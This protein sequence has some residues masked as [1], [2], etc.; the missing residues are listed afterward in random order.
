LKL[1][2]EHVPSFSVLHSV[3]VR[4]E[5]VVVAGSYALLRRVGDGPWEVLHQGAKGRQIQCVLSTPEGF[6]GLAWASGKGTAIFSKDGAKWTGRKTP[7]DEPRALGRAPD[8]TLVA[9]GRWESGYSRDGGKTWTAL[10]RGSHHHPTTMY[11][12]GHALWACSSAGVMRWNGAGWDTLAPQA[13]GSVV[14]GPETWAVGGIDGLHVLDHAKGAWTRARVTGQQPWMCRVARAPDGRV[15]ATGQYGFFAVSND[16]GRSYTAMDLGF[17]GDLEGMAFDE[18]G[19]VWVV[20]E[21]GF[22]AG[23]REPAPARPVAGRPVATRFANECLAGEIVVVAD[24]DRTWAER[25]AE[26]LWE[27]TI[28]SCQYQPSAKGHVEGELRY[29]VG[30]KTPWRDWQILDPATGAVSYRRD[31]R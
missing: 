22:V 3:A 9:L 7:A 31:P 25:G 15:F 21:S 2:R 4:G 5:T 10:P 18:N 6:V 11:D 23:P 28:R 27:R 20:G 19:D 26:L 1:N 30:E 12:D 16:E 24:N 14:I 17:G 29:P 8:G 13:G